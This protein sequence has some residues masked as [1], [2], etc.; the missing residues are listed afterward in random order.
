MGKKTKTGKGRLDKFY[1]LAKE[2]AFRS[3]SAFKLTQ[4]AKQYN[5][6]AKASIC[7]DLCGAPGGWSQVAVQSMPRGSKVI[8]VDLVP[9]KPLKGVTTIQSDITT[10]QC[11]NLIKQELNGKSHVCDI[12]LNDG[13]PNV[14]AAWSKD[15]YNQAEL[16]LHAFQMACDL[17]RPGGTFVTKVF[18][19]SDYNSLLWAFQQLFHKV[20]STKPSASRAVSA[21][22]F[23]VCQGFKAP[24]KIDPKFFNPKFVFMNEEFDNDEEM[25]EDEESSLTKKTTTTEK[26]S[27]LSGLLKAMGKRNRSG[28][29]PGDE[30]RTVT[31]DEFLASKNPAE[32]LIKCHKI[33]VPKERSSDVIP[34][35]IVGY[36]EDLKVLGK[37]EL[38]AIMKWRVKTLNEMRKAK[39]SIEGNNAED[40]SEDDQGSAESEKEAEEDNEDG[41]LR[42]LLKARQAEEKRELK[43][44]RVKDKKALMRKKMSL[45]GVVGIAES[46]SASFEP[47]LFHLPNVRDRSNIIVSAMEDAPAAIEEEVMEE[48][49]DADLKLA[50]YEIV[51]RG[52]DARLAQYE[53]DFAEEHRMRK[54]SGKQVAGTAA[55]ADSRG[56]KVTR[57]QKHMAAWAAEV[58]ALGDDMDKKS[59]AIKACARADDA[60]SSDESDIEE[61]PVPDLEPL[62]EEDNQTTPAVKMSSAPVSKTSSVIA[63][64]WFSNPIFASGAA[65]SDESDDEP[66]EDASKA[67]RVTK[68]L[69]EKD[70]P[71]IPLSDKQEKKRK[72]KEKQQSGGLVSASAGAENNEIEVVAAEQPPSL[73]EIAEIQAIG[74]LMTHKKSRLEVI[75]AGFNRYAR[76]DPEDLPDWFLEEEEKFTRKQLPLT[77]E[78]MQQYRAKLRE[79]NARPIRKEAEAQG[80][81]KRRMERK[82]ASLKQQASSLVMDDG[83]DPSAGQGSIHKAKQ[84]VRGM[85][86]VK[87]EG[88][89]KTV[90]LAVQ[91]RGGPSKQISGEGGRGAKVAMVDRRLKKDRRGARNAQRRN[92]G[93]R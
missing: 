8:C 82:M 19:S 69:D 7:V 75:E 11:R 5:L 47:D 76:D 53:L 68:E 44:Q 40:S 12:V 30:F 39:K 23:V 28:Y 1:H 50:Q 26:P 36:F 86:A 2:Q 34:E 13:A 35:S 51:E 78:L 22:I 90:F 31:V 65:D 55:V 43:R 32:Q 59:Y 45:D 41:E 49:V 93:R 66:R 84:I 17:L 52:N 16:T 88:K 42:R 87:R 29:A 64:R 80:R 54:E 56:K 57:R 73:D 48:E 60:P 74:S 33:L 27:S 6:F 79:I 72:R 77:K 3:R 4:L 38:Y 25:G 67:S 71:I 14:G 62:D 46:T 10:H 70:L 20:E 63:S 83:D 61:S 81:R 9:I 91:K 89:R 21:E 24:G 18:R 58:E 85:K 15:A 92:K 37:G